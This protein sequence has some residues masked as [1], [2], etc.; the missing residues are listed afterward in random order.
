V[1]AFARDVNRISF[2]PHE[3]VNVFALLFQHTRPP[4]RAHYKARIVNHNGFLMA[5][6]FALA[7]DGKAMLAEVEVDVNVHTGE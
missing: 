3:S 7:P 4:C 1:E 5:D 2:A 6:H